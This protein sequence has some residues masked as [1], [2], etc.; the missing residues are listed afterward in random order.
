MRTG[1]STQDAQYALDLVKRICAEIG[2]GL[3]GSPQE[4]E[5]AE[6]IK[7]ALESHVG[8]EN[9][10]IEEFTFAP[11]ALLSTYPG[12]LCMFAAVLLN[13]SAGRLTG[14]S[15]WITSIAA[16]VFSLI[17]PLSF[18]LEFLLSLE[19]TDLFF[20]KKSSLIPNSFAC[21]RA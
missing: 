3:P 12:A 18:V 9:V 8:P 19:V 16:L 14:V 15:A 17:T 6:M 2:P 11:D 5:R 7:K 10:N 13:V 20:A 4:R 21:D 1:V